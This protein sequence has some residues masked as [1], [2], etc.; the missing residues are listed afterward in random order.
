MIVIVSATKLLI[1]LFEANLFYPF[2]NIE[3]KTQVF[4]DILQLSGDVL[5]PFLNG[6]IVWFELRKVTAGL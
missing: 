2:K 1:F 4:R 5:Y 3:Y 6:C